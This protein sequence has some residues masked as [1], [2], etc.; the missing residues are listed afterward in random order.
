MG[1]D[2]THTLH[3]NIYITIIIILIILRRAQWPP[4]CRCWRRKERPHSSIV[5][6]ERQNPISSKGVNAKWDKC[7]VRRKIQYLQ[8]GSTKNKTNA[9]SNNS[10]KQCNDRDKIWYLQKSKCSDLKKLHLQKSQMQMVWQ[11][12]SNLFGIG[13]Q[14]KSKVQGAEAAPVFTWD[15]S[16]SLSHSSAWPADPVCKIKVCKSILNLAF[17]RF[18]LKICNS[19]FTLG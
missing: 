14:C 12:K 5:W 11:T 8:K 4:S 10:K 19:R 16:P 9:K 18:D 1:S 6:P 15:Y 17:C 2:D 3:Q 7:K 13:L